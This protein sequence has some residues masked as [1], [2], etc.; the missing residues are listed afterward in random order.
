TMYV[1][2]VLKHIIVFKCGFFFIRFKKTNL[3]T[4]YIGSIF[5][6]INIIFII[7][8]HQWTRSYNWIAT[9]KFFI[10]A[11]KNKY[12]SKAKNS[13]KILIKKDMINILSKKSSA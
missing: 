6:I 10:K 4:F 8:N 12:F 11:G 3:F 1:T 13:N 5:S 2:D 7:S 9:D